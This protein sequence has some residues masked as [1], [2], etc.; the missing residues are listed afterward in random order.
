MLGRRLHLRGRARKADD[1]DRLVG[2]VLRSVPR[3]AARVEAPAVHAARRA[4][5]APP[6][7]LDG[8]VAEGVRDGVRRGD[9]NERLGRHDGLWKRAIDVSV[10]LTSELRNHGSPAVADT[11]RPSAQRFALQ[12]HRSDAAERD[13]RRDTDRGKRRDACERRVCSPTHHGAVFTEGKRC[14]AHDELANRRAGRESTARGGSTA[15]GVESND[16]T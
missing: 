6:L 1:L 4:H 11:R 10:T 15:C 9:L 5:G 3:L 14:L 16:A 13:G 7:R 8:R 12:I 2:V